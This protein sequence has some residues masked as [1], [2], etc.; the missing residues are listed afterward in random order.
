MVHKTTHAGQRPEL[1]CIGVILFYNRYSMFHTAVK[2]INSKAHTF[3][4]PMNGI[5]LPFQT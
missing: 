5:P 1:V 2:T 3:N 4:T